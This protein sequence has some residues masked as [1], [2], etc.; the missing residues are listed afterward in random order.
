MGASIQKPSVTLDAKAELRR[1]FETHKRAREVEE[2][3]SGVR[4]VAHN[5][6]DFMQ[7]ELREP[8]HWRV[9][10]YVKKQNWVVDKQAALMWIEENSSEMRGGKKTC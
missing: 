10:D 7:V 1:Y 3:C 9:L 8:E 5:L 6:E 4:D 2:Y